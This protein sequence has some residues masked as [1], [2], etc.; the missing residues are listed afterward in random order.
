MSHAEKLK[1]HPIPLR[2]PIHSFPSDALIWLMWFL[3]IRLMSIFFQIFISTPFKNDS[4]IDPL[5]A[6]IVPIIL[7]FPAALCKFNSSKLQKKLVI[8]TIFLNSL[9]TK[10]V[11][12]DL[13]TQEGEDE[14]DNRNH[15]EYS[16]SICC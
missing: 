15:V 11:K 13:P 16:V 4:T 3:C 14:S 5:T 7:A 12:S 9:P 2:T 1:Q 8:T 10:V 6:I